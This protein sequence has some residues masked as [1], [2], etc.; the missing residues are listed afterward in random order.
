MPTSGFRTT[1][2]CSLTPHASLKPL[3]LALAHNAVKI[4]KGKELQRFLHP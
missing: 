2:P 1:R 4:L 3:T